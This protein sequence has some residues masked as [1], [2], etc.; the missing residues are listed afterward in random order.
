M[1]RK[2]PSA[3]LT[4]SSV[5]WLAFATLGMSSCQKATASGPPIANKAALEPDHIPFDQCRLEL[6]G[7]S[8]R[9]NLKVTESGDTIRID[10]VAA[11]EVLETEKYSSSDTAFS[12]IEAGGETYNPPIPIIRYPMHIGDTWNWTGIID[13]GGEVHPTKATVSTSSQDLTIKGGIVHNVVRIDIMLSIDSGRPSNPAT[14]KMTFWIAPDMGV[15]KRAF[16]DYSS[17]EPLEG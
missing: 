6:A 1:T 5:A 16:G 11:G 4:L 8:F 7:S 9:A 14:R 17:R 15:V 12:V 2:G 3:V 13:T 10:L